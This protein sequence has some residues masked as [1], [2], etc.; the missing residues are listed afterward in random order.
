MVDAGETDIGYFVQVAQALYDHFSNDAARYLLFAKTIQCLL[1][2][3]YGVFD[4][5]CRKR[6]FLA[7]LTYAHVELLSIKNLAPL[8]PFDNHEGRFLNPLVS[9]E[10]PFALLAFASSVNSIA[11]VT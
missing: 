4:L 10:A 9:A 1:D 7:S 8:V 3:F 2:L 5:P 6:A 11:N